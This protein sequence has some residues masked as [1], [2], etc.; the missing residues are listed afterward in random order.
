MKRLVVIA[1]IFLLAGA[2]VNVAVAWGIIACADWQN[3]HTIQLEALQSQEDEWP[4]D[5]PQDWPADC[6]RFPP[7]HQIGW[8]LTYFS[9]GYGRNKNAELS[10]SAKKWLHA[11]HRRSYVGGPP[12]GEDAAL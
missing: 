1:V 5:V 6:W 4:H 7:Q 9:G 12:A 3:I 11:H 10:D 2:V 8:E